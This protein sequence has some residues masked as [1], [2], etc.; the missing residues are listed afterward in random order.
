MA[1]IGQQLLSPEVGWRRYDDTDSRILYYGGNWIIRNN[2]SNLYNNNSHTTLIV[3]NEVKFK[4]KSTKLRILATRDSSTH[5]GGSADVYIDEVKVGSY[6]NTRS[7]LQKCTLFFEIFNLNNEE[8]SV[9]IVITET[10]YEYG[11]LWDCIDIDADGYLLHPILNQVSSANEAQIGDCIPIHYTSLTSGQVGSISEVGTC[12]ADEIPVTGTPTPNGLAYLIMIGYDY[13]GRKMF[14]PDRNLQTGISW[15]AINNAGLITGKV[16]DTD[17]KE[18][19]IRLLTGG[20]SSSDIENEWDEIIVNSDLDGTITAGDNNIWHWNGIYSWTSTTNAIGA[21]YKTIRGNTLVSNSSYLATS[22]TAGFR[23]VILVESGESNKFLIKQ[24]DNYYSLKSEFYTD[25][26]FFPLTLTDGESPNDNDFKNNGFDDIN[27]L[28]KVI[29]SDSVVT[30]ESNSEI[31]DEGN[32]FRFNIPDD[33]KD[34][35]KL[36]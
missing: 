8:H 28:V 12:I 3:G 5:V 4:F 21:T 6:T 18:V 35:K 13:L 9:R 7:T 24:G 11:F 29:T 16:I 17:N 15:D 34:I 23:P 2:D 10:F 19:E 22:S 31:L 1:T 36:E 25:N 32:L 14:I 30:I 27:D 33:F 26:Q 20:I